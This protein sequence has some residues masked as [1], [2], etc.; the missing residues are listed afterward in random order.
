MF[1]ET[2][3][4]REN[5]LLDRFGTF[6]LEAGYGPGDRL[7]SEAE[8]ATRFGVSRG[9]LR[10]VIMHL[11]FLGVLERA[12]SRGTHVCA[13]KSTSI[14]QD[15]AFRLEISGY[16]FAELKETRLCMETAVLPLVVRRFTPEHEEA[17][18][19]NIAEMEALRDDPEQ[20]DGLDKEFH[21][22]LFDVCG[23][24]TLR[25]FSH[26]TARLFDQVFRE[27]FLNPDAVMKS[28]GNHRAVLAAIAAADTASAGQL[29]AAHIEGT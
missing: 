15:L 5:D 16:S 27:K 14:V 11:C 9:T 17:L 22:G 24:R 13:V 10:E 23:N 3:S 19:A 20:A 21:L 4:M 12:T 26:V 1:L 28:A 18:L 7:P 2:D 29:L 25:L 8:L 6:L